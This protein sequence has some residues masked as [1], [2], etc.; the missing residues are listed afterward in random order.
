MFVVRVG[1][2]REKGKKRDLSGDLVGV[3]TNINYE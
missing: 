3:S 2:V 1:D